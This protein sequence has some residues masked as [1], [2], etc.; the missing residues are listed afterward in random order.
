MH[1]PEY[2]FTPN[3]IDES[4]VTPPSPQVEALKAFIQTRCGFKLSSSIKKASK[5]TDAPGASQKESFCGK[6]CLVLMND[7]QAVLDFVFGSIINT[8][9]DPGNW[10]R[11]KARYEN[12]WSLWISLYSLM[13]LP[14][15][16]ESTTASAG[17][18]QEERHERATEFQ[19]LADRFHRAYL[20]VVGQKSYMNHY[21]HV[22]KDHLADFI[23]EYGDLSKYSTQ[24]AEHMHVIV[25]YAFKWLTNRRVEERVVQA[26]NSVALFLHHRREWPQSQR[27]RKTR[28]DLDEC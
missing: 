25:N 22:I 12:V 6:E 2:E 27:L 4:V 21:V 15:P 23:R 11:D 3:I 14:I 13:V 19:A 7:Y 26:F 28:P 5:R 1:A 20:S 9:E 24:G 10:A 18:T 8:S 17:P 16:K